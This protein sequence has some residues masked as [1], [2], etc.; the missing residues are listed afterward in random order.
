MD[1]FSRIVIKQGA[2]VPT[3]PV[4]AD[5]RNGD[6]IATDIYEGEF[7]LDTTNKQLYNRT[8]SGIVKT[9]GTEKTHV[10]R[11]TQSGTNAPVQVVGSSN[12]AGTI[13]YAYDAPG[14]YRLISTVAEFTTDKTFCFTGGS[15]VGFATFAPISTT[16]IAIYTYNTSGVQANTWLSCDL[17]IEIYL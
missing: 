12:L 1:S 10:C 6:W 2:G 9:D 5:H 17:K 8:S 11:L 15:Q 3:V 4:S 13:S 7:Y 14:A 16:E